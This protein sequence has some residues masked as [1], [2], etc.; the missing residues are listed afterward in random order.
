VGSSVFGAIVF[1]AV[2]GQFG[3]CR[4]TVIG[5]ALAAIHAV[6]TEGSGLLEPGFRGSHARLGEWFIDLLSPK[7]KAARRVDLK[8]SVLLDRAFDLLAAHRPVFDAGGRSS[9]DPEYARPIFRAAT[10]VRGRPTSRR[11]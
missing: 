8:S 1:P 10:D 5:E 6:M 2:S 3:A 9:R 11:H 4:A 7:L